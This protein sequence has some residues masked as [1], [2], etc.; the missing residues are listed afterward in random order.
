[1]PAIQ[2]S[3]PPDDLFVCP[4]CGDSLDEAAIQ[5]EILAML[6]RKGDTVASGLQ[7]FAT[8]KECDAELEAYI[9]ARLSTENEVF[10]PVE[11]PLLAWRA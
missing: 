8:C 2:G 1:M 9:N 5:L 10:S 11:E 7:V 3:K 4:M 6:Q